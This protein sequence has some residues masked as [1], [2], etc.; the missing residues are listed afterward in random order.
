[1][2]WPMSFARRG[3]T[4]VLGGPHPTLLPEEAAQHADSV[5]IGEA[6]GV[7]PTLIRDFQESRLKL[8]YRAAAPPSLAGLPWARRELIERRA[9]GRGVLIATRSC[10]NACGYCMLPH[11]Y[12]HQYRCRPSE[13]VIAEAASIREKALIFWDDNIIGR[14]RLCPRTLSPPDSVTQTVDQP[15][16]IQHRGSR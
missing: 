7:W 3:V 15:G 10:P 11:F 5:L 16:H 4:V 9:Y 1:M 12:H 8:F 14:H 13:E 2:K 6:E